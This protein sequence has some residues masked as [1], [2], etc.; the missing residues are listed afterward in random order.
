[1]YPANE[2]YHLKLGRTSKPQRYVGM[3]TFSAHLLSAGGSTAAGRTQMPGAQVT[4]L[5]QGRPRC[6]PEEMSQQDPSALKHHA[7]MAENL[8]NSKYHVFDPI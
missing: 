5:C 6:R 2:I 1:L 8:E 3:N 4:T 7:E